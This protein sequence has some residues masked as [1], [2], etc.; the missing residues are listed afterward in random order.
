MN[1]GNLM[2]P[3]WAKWLGLAAMLALFIGLLAWANTHFLINPA[4]NAETARWQSRWDQRD[5]R[6]KQAQIDNQTAKAATER[7]RQDEID[8]IQKDAQ[9]EISRLAA[10]RAAA[11][12]NSERLQ[13]SIETAIGRL[14]AGQAASTSTSGQAGDSTAVLLAQLYRE[15]DRAA[16][17]YAAEADRARAA[18]LTCEAAYDAL[19][20]KR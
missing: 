11:D 8:R 14:R 12:R 6:D 16:G 20:A 1:V 9:N 4:V 3:T 7:A 13:Q 18:G 15:I 2:V 10:L 17:D 19:R 5:L